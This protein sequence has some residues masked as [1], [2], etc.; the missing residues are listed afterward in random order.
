MPPAC[1]NRYR[2]ARFHHLLLE[3]LFV[4]PQSQDDLAL[5]D[6]HPL[7]FAAVV[8]EAE[9]VPFADEQKFAGVACI[10]SINDLPAPRLLYYFRGLR[11]LRSRWQ[12]SEAGRYIDGLRCGCADG[13]AVSVAKSGGGLTRGIHGHRVSWPRGRATEGSHLSLRSRSPRSEFP[14]QRRSRR[15]W[16]LGLGL[17]V[18]TAAIAAALALALSDSG[19]APSAPPTPDPLIT[20]LDSEGAST[21]PLGEGR[22]RQPAEQSSEREATDA[23]GSQSEAKQSAA[24]AM[25]SEPADPR[26]LVQPLSVRQGQTALVRLVGTEV[27]EAF[28]TIEGVTTPMV[29]EEDVWIG[30]APVSPLEATG[31]I[32]VVVDVFNEFGAY[33]TTYLDEVVVAASNAGVE[34]IT[35][36]PGDDEL[37]APEIVALDV[38]ERFE[39]HVAVNGPRLWTGRWRAPVIA[40]G[41]GRFGVLR[42]YNGA[43]PSDWHHGH[44][45][46]ATEGEPIVAPAAGVVVFAGE[47]PVHGNGVILDHGAGVYSGYWHMAAVDVPLGDQVDQGDRLGFVGNTGLSVGAHLHWEVI[48]HGQDVDPVQW[49]ESPLHE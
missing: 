1:G 30:Y 11:I 35:L 15:G 10:R 26:I 42:S 39:R 44:D 5:Q 45:F 27:A 46:S 47:L 3:L 19:D 17:T 2:R 16:L 31:V 12:G 34:E 49:L 28:L 29:Q 32:A 6:L 21:A 24:D 18:T 22:V 23:S 8:L 36:E 13:R 41:S 14:L 9:S 37:L 43:P 33:L 40:P 38:A 4:G 20:D 25:E 7:V 48:V